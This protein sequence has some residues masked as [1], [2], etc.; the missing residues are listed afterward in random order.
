M[1]HRELVKL[2]EQNITLFSKLSERLDREQGDYCE[3]TRQQIRVL[4]RLFLNGRAKLKDIAAREFVPT[5]NLCT[6]FRKLEN[7]GLVSRAV[8]ENDRRNTWYSVTDR[9]EEIAKNV[10][11]M[12]HKRIGIMFQG[13]SS[14][15]EIELVRSFKT[16]NAILLKMEIKN[17]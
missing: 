6:A 16:I 8:D 15:D 14:D 12:F 5:P 1:I 3:Y 10:I 11:S 13:I 2:I 7:D 17:A 9:G 4:V